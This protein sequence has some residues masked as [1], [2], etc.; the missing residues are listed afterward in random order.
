MADS[1]ENRTGQMLTQKMVMA[2]TLGAA[3]RGVA[4]PCVDPLQ[5]ID[6][7]HA[8]A[9]VVFRPPSRNNRTGSP[10]SSG[11]GLPAR[12]QP[13]TTLSNNLFTAIT[14]T[15]V[16]PSTDLTALLSSHRHHR[17]GLIVSVSS[18]RCART[19]LAAAGIPP[20]SVHTH[21][22]IPGPKPIMTFNTL[23]VPFARPLLS[24]GNTAFPTSSS[25][26]RTT[27]TRLP[28]FMTPRSNTSATP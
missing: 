17:T 12:P 15:L 9:A 1:I 18:Y 7:D 6:T 13:S 19:C 5:A 14:P 4:T 27:C 10:H 25:A 2:T 21:Q 23:L 8:R 16:S 28:R 22:S 26:G 3:T 20:R 11:Q 24:A